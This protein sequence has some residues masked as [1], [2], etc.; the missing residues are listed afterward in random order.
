MHDFPSRARSRVATW[1]AVAALLAL[2]IPF[3]AFLDGSVAPEH[4]FARNDEG[5][6]VPRVMGFLRG[7]W[8]DFN[9]INPTFSLHLFHAATALFGL[10]LVLVGRFESFAAF[11]A[12][13]SSNPY[14]VTV[15]A[16]SLAIGASVATVVVFYLAARRLFSAPVALLAAAALAVDK[17]HVM[18][19]PLAGSESS[20]MLF[21]VLFL[22]AALRYLEAPSARRHGVAGVALGLA[23]ATKYNAGIHVI[24]LLAASLLVLA[25]AREEGAPLGAL[26]RPRF[27]AGFLAAPLAFMAASPFAIMHLAEFVGE[28]RGQVDDF[29]GEGMAGIQEPRSGWTFYVADFPDSNA[30][31]PFAI[32]CGL[33]L[34]AAIH[35]LAR[36]RDARA[37]LLLAG[38]LPCYLALGSGLFHQMRFLLPAIPFLLALGAW[39]LGG[40]VG[41]LAER[42]LRGERARHRPR[43][44]AAAVLVLGGLALAPAGLANLRGVRHAFGRVDPRGELVLWLRERLRPGATYVTFVHP[45]RL[46]PLSL[47]VYKGAWVPSEREDVHLVPLVD[48]VRQAPTF[49]ELRAELERQGPILVAMKTY[50]TVLR[51]GRTVADVVAE[52]LAYSPLIQSSAYGDE[53]RRYVSRLVR[54]SV[55][56]GMCRTERRAGRRGDLTIVCV[57]EPSGG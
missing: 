21:V 1:L 23:A 35:G 19:T 45:P 31:L 38:G 48:L 6:Y 43:A 44:R 54:K 49:A 57:L 55:T 47:Q 4:V 37:A 15:A 51:K 50:G 11:S 25:R 34:L 33:G 3:R 26:R 30:G 22:L 5:H 12:E 52:G 16:R 18:R 7:E 8:S 27:W 32:L 17:T 2:A 53:L 39:A 46:S 9:F 40:I 36:R 41:W 10:G 42:V 20:M 56:R 14:F 13:A 24:T 28:F 29:L